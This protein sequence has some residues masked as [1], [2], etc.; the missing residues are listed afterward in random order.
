MAEDPP[1]I[2]P[3]IKSQPDELNLM[4]LLCSNQDGDGFGEALGAH[5]ERYQLNFHPDQGDNSFDQEDEIIRPVNPNK[6]VPNMEDGGRTRK[7]RKF[8]KIDCFKRGPDAIKNCR[9]N[10]FNVQPSAEKE[11]IDELASSFSQI[12]EEKI[13]ESP[14]AKA[15]QSMMSVSKASNSGFKIA[16]AQCEENT[17]EEMHT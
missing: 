6:H 4:D 11:D 13:E 1:K 3:V 17:D 2:S 14:P 5:A 16:P 10:L 7:F 8:S 9:K 15:N 12:L